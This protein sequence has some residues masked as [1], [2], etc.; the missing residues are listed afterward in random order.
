MGTKSKRTEKC[1]K[2]GAERTVYIKYPELTPCLNCGE[3]ESLDK[4]K[5]IL[6]K[7]KKK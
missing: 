1:K 4:I 3:R 7:R 6:K 2:C 5:K